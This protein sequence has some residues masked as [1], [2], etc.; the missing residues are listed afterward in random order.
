MLVDQSPGSNGITPEVLRA[1]WHFIGKE[2]L[3][4]VRC[5]WETGMITFKILDGIIKL[6][7]K[8]ANK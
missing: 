4:M 8:T 2:V 3:E 1:F 5:F 7:P 6:I